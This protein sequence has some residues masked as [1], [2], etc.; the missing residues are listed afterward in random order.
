VLLDRP[1][2]LLNACRHDLPPSAPAAILAFLGT[3]GDWVARERVMT[4]LWPDASEQAAQHHLRVTLHRARQIM[5]P[6]GLG[7]HL[8][9]ERRR[10]RL[11]MPSDV[12]AFRQAV[13]RADWAQA[14][15][16]HAAPLLSSFNL[17]G[18][19]AFDEW[20]SLERE[21][22]T[23][24]WRLAAL[25]Q[26]AALE[27]LG[28]AAAAAALLQAQ[29]H[30]DLLAEDT[31][32]ALLRVA[33]AAGARD[34]A[35]HAYERFC[36]RARDE[37][38]LDPLPGTQALAE[39]LRRAEPRRP[40]PARTSTPGS[41]PLA[42]MQAPLVGRD[43]ERVQL[44]HAGP[45]LTLVSGE[46]GVGKSR[47]VAEARAGS[48]WVRCGEDH[49]TEPL[50][51]IVEALQA[52]SAERRRAALPQPKDR[53]DLAMLLP[54]MAPGESTAGAPTPAGHLVALLATLLGRLTEAGGLIIDDLQWADEG[55]MQVLQVLLE[56]GQ[57]VV[58]TVRNQPL[59]ERLQHVID[60]LDLQGRLQRCVLDPLPRSAMDDLMRLLAG[61]E[62]PRFAQWLHARSAGNPFLAL[63]T[64][65]SLFET[66][67]LG[68]SDAGWQ[69]EL[70]TL[71]VDDRALPVPVRVK[72]L[73]RLRVAAL[74][75]TAR[76][77]MAVAALAGDAQHLE[78]LAQVAGLS[79]WA[80]A[81]AVAAAQ[82]AGLLR[83]REFAHDLLREAL[84]AETP[85][86]VQAVLHAGIARHAGDWLGPH[87]CAAHW[88]AAG[89]IDDALTPLMQAFEQDR[90]FGLTEAAASLLKHTLARC[91]QPWQRAQ[92]L[93]LQASLAVDTNCLDDADRLAEQAL[94]SLPRPL[95]RAGALMARAMVAL[96]RGAV[97]RALELVREAVRAAPDDDSA[98][99]LH[100]RAAWA[101]G[102]LETAVPIVEAVLDR[103]RRQP[104]SHELVDVLGSLASLYASQGRHEAAL[105][106]AQEA[107]S[108][109]DRLGARYTQVGSAG[110]LVY[111][112]T[113][114]GRVAEAIDV[115]ERAIALGDYD[116]TRYVR[117]SLVP[118]Y[119]EVDRLDDAERQ[120]ELL[121]ASGDPSMAC[122]A[123]AFLA[124][125]QFRRG[126]V[127]ATAIAIEQALQALA[128]TEFYGAQ[129]IAITAVVRLGNDAQ[130]RQ[131]LGHWR[132]Q[133]LLPRVREKLDAALRERG[134]QPPDKQ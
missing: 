87:R 86:P 60:Q 115:G 39:S 113:R 82:S 8:Q 33:A 34:A 133:P 117:N 109:A 57:V 49:R 3:Q 6:W 103:Y 32:Q 122:T 50:Y 46:P 73:V 99:M 128:N 80:M 14:V 75:E 40:S 76:R 126:D 38:G 121:C 79:P 132:D 106:A 20:V 43:T 98:Q 7:E 72:A 130:A 68:R 53:R 88:W 36:R 69:S 16:L 25:R 127:V 120:C 10:L 94:Q 11:D 90:N 78:P 62:A 48:L 61:Q 56:R 26:A 125:I 95:A 27:G 29:L 110:S 74:P 51:G 66:G 18:F 84:L 28:N 5:A 19:A 47:L 4:L 22:L 91:E 112:L 21:S 123:R 41:V 55:L 58:A 42:V 111:L 70:D 114:T 97:Q 35:L 124:E 12:V 59:D 13:S 85:E 71:S 108:L 92:V 9:T 45:G 1:H 81:E 63:E 131:A 44:A 24:A 105:A 119:F 83:G 17:R 77:A 93:A 116:G 2:L 104:P 129:A 30:D 107:W 54:D 118:A 100:A 64:L 102:D 67:L 89:N 15:A 23:A 52:V 101:A 65:R 134:L 96:H 31:L 37:L